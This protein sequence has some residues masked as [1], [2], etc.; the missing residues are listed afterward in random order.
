MY[1]SMS[2]RLELATAGDAGPVDAS[3]AAGDAGPVD[4]SRV[5]TD[6]RRSTHRIRACR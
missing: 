4:A 3:R 1:D 5:A 2:T 6:A